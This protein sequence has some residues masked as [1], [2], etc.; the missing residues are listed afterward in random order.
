MCYKPQAVAKP[1]CTMSTT[2]PLSSSPVDAHTIA[3]VARETGIQKDTLRV[4][5]R[6]YGF[7]VPSRDAAGERRY[8]ADQLS[9]LRQ[10]KRLLDAGHRP[11][12]VVALPLDGLAQHI[13]ALS[14]GTPGGRPVRVA[15]GLAAPG[16]VCDAPVADWNCW[17]NWVRDGAVDALQQA[18][19]QHALKHG[20]V[21]T[22][23]GLLGQLGH[24]VGEAWLAGDIT[25][26]QEHLYTEAAQRFLQDALSAADRQHPAPRRAPRV[27]LTTL[28]GEMHTL[29]LLMAECL[30]ALEGCERRA[31]GRDTPVSDVVQAVEHWQIDVVAL[32]VSALPAATAVWGALGQLRESLPSHV[33][34]WVGG[35]SVH[36][37]RR[38]TPDGIWVMQSVQALSQQVQRWRE[39]QA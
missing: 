20:L 25:V 27:L 5:E 33:A 31:L 29:G 1:L 10:I 22:I 6:R 38:H 9:R 30:L 18:L 32:S 35:S 11:G 39:Q 37:R 16:P 17:M 2:Q 12:G 4:W 34:I 13:K 7:P 3:D 21:Q 19:G 8:G 26:Y 14:A 36:L 28:P 15:R 24:A 23:D